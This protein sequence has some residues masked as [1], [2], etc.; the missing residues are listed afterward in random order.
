MEEQ[1]FLSEIFSFDKFSA[2]VSFFVF[3]FFSLSLFSHF[4]RNLINTVVNDTQNESQQY[5]ENDIFN[6]IVFTSD[7]KFK[8]RYVLVFQLSLIHI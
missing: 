4:N 3:V 5:T 6:K 2:H 1:E 8:S 7:G